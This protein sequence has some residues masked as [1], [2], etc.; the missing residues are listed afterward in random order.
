VRLAPDRHVY[1]L[2]YP[3]DHVLY[4]TNG[5]ISDPRFSR[6]G[7]RIAFLDHPIFGDDQGFVAVVDLQGHYERLSESFGS[8]QRLAWS[9]DGTEIRFSAVSNGVFA[10][11]L[12]PR[13]ADISALYF[14][15]REI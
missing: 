10:L 3:V 14:P 2:Q 7:R 12:P 13:F 5:W 11:S 9:P 6:D 15:L 4:E 1:R 8:A